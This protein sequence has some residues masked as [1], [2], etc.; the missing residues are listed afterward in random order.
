[1]ARYFREVYTICIVLSSTALAA[2]RPPH[3]AN[4]PSRIWASEPGLNLTD[5]YPLGNGRLGAISP[6][7]ATSDHITLNEDSFWSGPLLKRVNP[8]ALESVA[9]MQAQVRQGY[10]H[11]AQILGGFGYAATP[12]ST[13]H[14]EPLGY[15]TLAQNITGNITNYERWLDLADATSGVFFTTEGITYQ[16]EFLSSNPADVIAIHLNASERGSLNFNIHLDRDP[17]SLNRWEDYS[18]PVNGDTIIMGGRSG[19][20]GSMGFATGARVVATGGKVTTLGDYVIC[21]GADE[22]YIYVSARTTYH[23]NDTRSVVLSDLSPYNANSYNSIRSDHVSDYKQYYDRVDL[24][25]GISSPK[26][27]NMST[28]AR[29]GAITPKNFDPDLAVLYFQYARYL[30]IATSR[31]G[32]LPPNLQGI[33]NEDFDPMWGSKYTININLRM[34]FDHVQSNATD[35]KLTEMNYWPLLPTGKLDSSLAIDRPVLTTLC[36]PF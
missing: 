11:Q 3:S 31:N 4:I 17:S 29:M 19:G 13:Q 18:Q 23:V 6:G 26:Q 1:M 24:S 28:P 5:G 10:P 2:I 25:L 8:D 21:T 22:A 30:L 14:Y 35:T 16:R 9:N 7:S 27:K 33:W 32:T 36:R 15:M 12:V 20:A 34:Y